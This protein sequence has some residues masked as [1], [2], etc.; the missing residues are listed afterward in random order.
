LVVVAVELEI[1]ADKL[2]LELVVA[3]AVVVVVAEMALLLHQGVLVLQVKEVLA[4]M[5]L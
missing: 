5:V 1:P 2:A 3:L 4:V